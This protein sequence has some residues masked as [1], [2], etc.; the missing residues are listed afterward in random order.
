MVEAKTFGNLL[1]QDLVSIV[2]TGEVDKA[3]DVTSRLKALN[4]VEAL[5]VYNKNKQAVYS[6]EK[7]NIEAISI[8]SENW[9]K[10]FELVD[11]SLFFY[12][13]LKYRESEYGYIFIQLS[14]T[15]INETIN[16][17]IQQVV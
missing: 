8:M 16:K 3:S 12:E 7:E 1:A 13:I 2:T 6:Y 14:A 9:Q 5:T 11:N 10:K 17:R 15:E 4:K